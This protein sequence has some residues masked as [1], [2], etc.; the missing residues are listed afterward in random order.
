VAALDAYLAFWRFGIYGAR[1]P[2]SK[3]KK[4]HN[5]KYMNPTSKNSI[6]ALMLAL[7]CSFSSGCGKKSASEAP[8]TQATSNA[9]PT[10][11]AN[12][13]TT[14]ASVANPSNT[15]T[16]APHIIESG[17]SFAGAIHVGDV[18]SVDNK[19][20]VCTH[21][22]Y[23][24]KD[25]Q[26]AASGSWSMDTA[27]VNIGGQLFNFPDIAILPCTD[28]T[29]LSVFPALVRS[30]I[31]IKAGDVIHVDG[32]EI[33]AKMAVKAGDTIDVFCVG[34]TSIV[35]VQGAKSINDTPWFTAFNESAKVNDRSVAIE[36]RQ[37][38]W[39]HVR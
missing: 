1:H 17:V 35:S 13:S 2:P 19:A 12:R 38:E 37:A 16:P 33:E 18:P 34:S 9:A 8:T 26:F 32:Y 22:S 31:D 11:T 5:M 27:S 20:F 15:A 7:V 21:A 4:S 28:G 23:L 10:Q 25:A 6:T 3:K 36:A 14:A 24:K 29:E 39:R 30:K